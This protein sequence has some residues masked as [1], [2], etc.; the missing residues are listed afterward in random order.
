MIDTY[1]VR[2]PICKC[3]RN[4]HKKAMV[5]L[6]YWSNAAVEPVKIAL[7]GCACSI[8]F[9]H[10]NL[11]AQCTRE[12]GKCE[13]AMS[14]GANGVLT[15]GKHIEDV[16]KHDMCQ[17]WSLKLSV[18]W[19]SGQNSSLLCPAQF[20]YYSPMGKFRG[21]ITKLCLI[22]TWKKQMQQ[23]YLMVFIWSILSKLALFHFSVLFFIASRKCSFCFL[24][25]TAN[26]ELN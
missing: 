22:S 20:F 16:A 26:V 3:K 19:Y 8:V 14:V 6:T 11:Q 1:P 7:G 24:D 12:I 25:I 2:V 18:P 21:I 4:A 15:P 17:A 13:P 9:P 23:H 5:G 10:I